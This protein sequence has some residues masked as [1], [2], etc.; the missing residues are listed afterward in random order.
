M[1]RIAI[2]GA[3]G[4]GA[5]HAR[6]LAELGATP[7]ALAATGLASARETAAVLR[8][9]LG[10]TL[11]PYGSVADC[12]ARARPEAVVVATPAEH[13][14]E[15]LEAVLERGLPVLCEKPLYWPG[16]DVGEGLTHLERTLARHPEARLMLNLPTRELVA[17]VQ[18]ELTAPAGEVEFEFHTLGRATGEAIAVD[19]LPHAFALLA[20][21][22]PLS[23]P[24]EELEV[25]F[26]RQRFVARFV[27]AGRHVRLELVAD[28]SGA[29]HLAFAIGGQR[30]VRRQEGSGASYRVFLEDAAGRRTELEDPFVTRAR[31][32]LALC[33]GRGDWQAARD[34]ALT[35]HEALVRF[36]RATPRRQRAA[37]EES[38]CLRA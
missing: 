14:A 30:F 12:L 20:G 16:G 3:R 23:A 8:T 18:G 11:E 24:F 28:P 34:E 21:L 35:N 31:R 38:P 6:V 33:A 29:K 1:R 25:E 5:V 19:L 22:G 7:C 10:L 2:L 15:H 13:H 27:Q 37:S 32:F 36:L 26:A 17:A 4:I 9:R